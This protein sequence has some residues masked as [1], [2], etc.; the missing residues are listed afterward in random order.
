MGKAEEQVRLF[1]EKL[2][3]WMDAAELAVDDQM[4]TRVRQFAQTEQG[5][6]LRACRSLEDMDRYMEKYHGDRWKGR[7]E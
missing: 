3:E 1:E 5:M 6:E 7:E 4:R 2:E